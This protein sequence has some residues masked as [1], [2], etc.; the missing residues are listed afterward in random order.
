[1]TTLASPPTTI[2]AHRTT[3]RRLDD[4]AALLRVI[5]NAPTIRLEQGELRSTVLTRSSYFALD[6]ALK[7]DTPHEPRAAFGLNL[8]DLRN[9]TDL[10]EAPDTP[11]GIRVL[12]NSGQVE[13]EYQVDDTTVTHLAADSDPPPTR[14]DAP[15]HIQHDA[16]LTISSRTLLRTVQLASTT[17]NTAT[18]TSERGEPATFIATSKRRSLHALL[19]TSN[20]AA[21]AR[22]S[23]DYLHAITTALHRISPTITLSWSTDAPLRLEARDATLRATY[24]QAPTTA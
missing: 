21:T 5:T 22:Y 14:R 10:I 7:L 2:L 8:V 3:K 13:I 23:L 18:L 9:L 11:I 19:P 24:L 16:T 20:G 17:S 4:I 1:M 15:F 6:L 12:T